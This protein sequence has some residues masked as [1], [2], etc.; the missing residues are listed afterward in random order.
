MA[1]SITRLDYCQFLLSSQINYTL[2]YFAEHSKHFSH[3][4]VNRYLAGER[5]TPRLLW[6]NVR[7]QVVPSDAGRASRETTSA[8][9]CWSG[10]D[11]RTWPTRA[12]KPSIRSST[13]C[14]RST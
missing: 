5:I 9:P 6:E 7:G 12:E 1:S 3:D 14:S 11:S 10:Y 4:L 8:V 13:T 2:T